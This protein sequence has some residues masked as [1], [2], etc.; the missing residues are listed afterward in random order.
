MLAALGVLA[1]GAFSGCSL[2]AMGGNDP[3][4][5]TAVV[6][7]NRSPEGH[8][9]AIAATDGPRTPR[10]TVGIEPARATGDEEE[11]FTVVAGFFHRTRALRRPG[12]DERRGA[13]RTGGGPALASARG[14]ARRPGPGG[15]DR[16]GRFVTHHRPRQE[17]ASRVAVSV[18]VHRDRDR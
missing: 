15:R 6:V 9:V 1:S 2:P 18:D 11:A 7:E 8:T 13:R 5:A 12:T 14:R 10:T 4:T 17:R 16:G 3:Y